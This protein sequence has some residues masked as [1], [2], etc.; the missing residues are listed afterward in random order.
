MTHSQ[1]IPRFCSERDLCDDL[2]LPLVAVRELIDQGL[3]PK[4]I[5]IRR[6][7]FFDR[8]AVQIACD[9]LSHIEQ[10]ED[11]QDENCKRIEERT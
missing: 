5:R 1:T 3:L 7:Y 6:R 10:K 11:S 8:V 9:R 4:P 2:G